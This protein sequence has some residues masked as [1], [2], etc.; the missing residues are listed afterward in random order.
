[1]LGD[2]I[3]VLS[4]DVYNNTEIFSATRIDSQVLRLGRD[5]GMGIFFGPALSPLRRQLSKPHFSTPEDLA[6]APGQGSR[7]TN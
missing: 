6:G 4:L 7:F 1:M 2:D 3:D 5:Y